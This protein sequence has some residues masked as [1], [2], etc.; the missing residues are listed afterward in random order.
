M[1]W[2]ILTSHEIDRFIIST[3]THED[4]LIYKEM[5]IQANTLILFYS[6]KQLKYSFLAWFQEVYCQALGDNGG[7]RDPQLGMPCLARYTDDDTW[8][9]AKITGIRQNGQIEETHIVA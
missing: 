7:V 6:A 1:Y 9:R 3:L 5:F 2:L 8:Y 4:K